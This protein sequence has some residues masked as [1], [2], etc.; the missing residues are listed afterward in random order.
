[1]TDKAS[2][3]FESASKRCDAICA[4]IRASGVAPDAACGFAD[5]SRVAV[6]GQTTALFDL[7]SLTKPVFAVSLGR[8]GTARETPLGELLTEAW[9]TAAAEVPLELLLAHRAGFP[10]HLPLFAPMVDGRPVDVSAA[11]AEA[12]RSRAPGPLP[13]P[14]LYSDLGYL[15]A[16]FAVAGADA[17]AFMDRHVAAPLGLER[18]LGSA[19]VLEARG[20]DVRGLAPPTETVAW[21]GGEVRGRVHDENAWALT[22]AG[23]CGHAGL[24]GTVGAVLRFGLFV[25]ERMGELDWLVREREGGTL[26]AGFD[27]KSP[28]GSSAGSVL[29]PRSF[30]HLG[31]TGTSFWIDPDAGI[32]VA[33]LTNRVRPTRENVRIREAR[34]RVHDELA[35]AALDARRRTGGG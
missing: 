18:E 4:Q 24:F 29:G 17:D 31:F 3:L 20:V 8:S 25:L 16:G 33:L 32:V 15:L 13:A 1:M 2:A 11:L 22:G 23:A 26:R 21:R 10:D 9:Q 34:P 5:A 12:C 6:G 27:G 14:P 28:Q 7:A 35:R 19:R 30:G